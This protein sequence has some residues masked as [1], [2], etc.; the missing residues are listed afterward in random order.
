MR[1]AV[2]MT[3]E[4]T[5]GRPGGA[6][7]EI[8]DKG[9][10]LV[11]QA[12]QQVHEKV[13]EMRGQAEVRLRDQVD[14]RSTQAGDQVQ[15]VGTALRRSAE[16]LREE[17]KE[18]PA[19]LVEQVAR[20]ADELGGYLQTTNADRMVGDIERF[21]RHRP[22]LTGA[23]GVLAGFLASRFV[24]ASSDRRYSAQRDPDRGIPARQEIAAGG[25]R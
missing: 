23:A 13:Q 22:W 21:A 9:Q 19:S 14:Q 1:G 11:S 7:A 8:Q 3:T 10:E 24:K 12:G 4:Q 18:T 20:R 5:S 2:D 16:Q 6:V 15:S 25:A 17:G